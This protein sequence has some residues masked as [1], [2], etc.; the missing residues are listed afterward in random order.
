MGAAF[1]RA[2]VVS[3]APIDL[4]AY[5]RAKE[6]GFVDV[7]LEG[8]NVVVSFDV[9]HGHDRMFVP[10]SREQAANLGAELLAIAGTE[11]DDDP[12]D[13]GTPVALRAAA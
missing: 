3:G 9:E 12:N 2:A 1:R 6:Q 13:G 8:E 7:E 4:G 11:D 10:L 5:R